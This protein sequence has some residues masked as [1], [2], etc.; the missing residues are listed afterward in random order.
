[1]SSLRRRLL[2]WTGTG[3]ALGLAAATVLTGVRARDSAGDLLDYQMA[4]IAAAVPVQAL[5][6]MPPDRL[7]GLAADE[8]VVI[9]IWDGAGV[10][11]APPA[12]A[13]GAAQEKEPGRIAPG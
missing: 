10:R 1:M 11:L 6:P 3:L 4:R 2:V 12:R 8:D 7:E 5:G 9:Q 13:A